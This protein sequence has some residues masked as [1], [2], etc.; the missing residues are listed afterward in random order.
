MKQ[1]SKIITI[2]LLF[3]LAACSKEEAILPEDRFEEYIDL[4]IEQDFSSMYQYLSDQALAEYDTEAFIE[5]Y[6]KIYDDLAITD[7]TID[8]SIPETEEDQDPPT[9]F[10]VTVTQQ[11]IAG[12]ISFESEITMVEKLDEDEKSDWKVDWHPGLIFPELKEGGSIAIVKTE[13]SRG[14][15]F[16]QYG[17]GLAINGTAYEIGVDPG[18]FTEQRDQEIKAIADILGISVSSIESALDQG[19]VTDGVFV[20]LKIIS[21]HEGEIIDEIMA[22]PAVLSRETT[23]R[24]YPYGEAMAHLIGYT[25]N[26]TAEELEKAE[27]GEYSEQDQIGK[28]GLEQLFEQRLRG[29][30]GIRI[31]VEHDGQ[32]TGI[33][34]RS[35]QPGED[36]G[37]TIDANIQTALYESFDGAAGTAAAIDPKTGETLA[38]VSSPSFDPHLFTYGISQ[39]QYDQLNEAP[40]QPM[41]NR[42]AATYSPGSSF[43]PITSMIG[44][45]N[46]SIKQDEAIEIEGLT[47]TKDGW[48]NFRVRRVSESNGPVDLRD[49][50]IR[51]DNIFFAQKALAIGEDAFVAGLEDLGFGEDGLPYTYPIRSSTISNDGGFNREALLADSGYG[52]G[53][54]L[55]SSLHLAAAYS[56]ILNDGA[57]IQPILEASEE[58]SQIFQ[59]QIISADQASYLRDALR[60]VVA[61][62][63]GTGQQANIDQ[64]DLSGKTG[65]AELKQTLDEESGTENG[66]F[67]AYPDNQELIIAMMVENVQEHGGSGYTTKKLASFF[68]EMY[69]N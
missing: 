41:L 18:Q 16:D 23:G 59:D 48:G 2:I 13:T 14:E 51:S 62:P 43:K 52:Q 34:E 49:A 17:N 60:Q 38:L 4:W 31:V 24:V 66:W 21:P 12:E 46:G 22:I 54:I 56:A 19:W 20:P 32:R 27:P 65:T 25:G 67:V 35:P 63:N 45:N 55:M 37:L 36:I 5:R 69:Q 33:A 30:P 7:L 57:M 11:S 28:R 53:E 8:Y 44:L 64:V 1:L 3:L 40:D 47:W 29:E 10:P 39:K 42:F 26:I 9:V 50:L 58:T 68:A 61:S 15:I 6:Q